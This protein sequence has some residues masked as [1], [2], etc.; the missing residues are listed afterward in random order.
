MSKDAGDK[1]YRHGHIVEMEYSG[2]GS[3]GD[4]VKMSSGQVTPV[5][6][7]GDPIVGVIAEDVSSNSSGDEVSV[8][9]HGTF[10]VTAD[11]TVTEGELLQASGSTNG[12]LVSADS[13]EGLVT[14]VDESGSATYDVYSK[15]AMALNDASDGE[16]VGVL[17]G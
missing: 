5:T 14:A 2:T 15:Y 3:E 10:Y 9:I 11:G 7:N 8:G 12:Q 1:A 6:A 16:L 17:L 4:V 13:A